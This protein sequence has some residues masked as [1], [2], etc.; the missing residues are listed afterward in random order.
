MTRPRIAVHKNI[1]KI[2]QDTIYSCNLRV[3]QS[4]GLQFYQTRSSFTTL[5][6]RCGSRRWWSCSQKKNCTAK[7]NTSLIA[8]QRVVLK[9][10]L[11][12]EREDT[13]SSD[14]RKSFDHCDKHGGKHR[15]TCRGEIDFRIQGLH[16]SAV[17]E[18]DHIRKQAVQKLMHQFEIHPSKAALQEVLQQNRAFNPFT[19]KSK[20]HGKHGVLRDLRD[21]TPTYNARI[22]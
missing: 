3:A 4:K 15:E 14:V 2:H 22:V 1:W 16:H 11:N 9:P 8:P 6:L 19:E 18:H 20:E 12:Y 13:T 5:Y 17:Q 21:H 7:R 10:N